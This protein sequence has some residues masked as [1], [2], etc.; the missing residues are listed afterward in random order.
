MLLKKPPRPAKKDLRDEMS[1]YDFLL[2]NKYFSAG[3][4]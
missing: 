2:Q 1:K 3:I 4:P